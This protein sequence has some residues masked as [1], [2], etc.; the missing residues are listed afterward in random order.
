L[1]SLFGRVRAMESLMGAR[2]GE[3]HAS[4]SSAWAF[5]MLH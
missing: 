4:T 5:S 3:A 1:S 2:S